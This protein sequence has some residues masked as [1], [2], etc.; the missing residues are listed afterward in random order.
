MRLEAERRARETVET[1]QRLAS[2]VTATAE[3]GFKPFWFAV[4]VARPLMSDK[5]ALEVV[6]ELV[7]GTW[8]LAVE[9]RGQGFLPMTPGGLYGFLLDTSGIQRG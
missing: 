5:G 9:R 1:A 8:Y 3:P 2:A 6:G 4:P 7:P